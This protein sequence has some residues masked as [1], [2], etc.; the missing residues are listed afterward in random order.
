MKRL[1]SPLLSAEE[2]KNKSITVQELH[3][4]TEPKSMRF[5]EL[6]GSSSSD[7]SRFA[8]RHLRARTKGQNLDE[9]GTD[10]EEQRG[11]PRSKS[12]KHIRRRKTKSG[13]RP[14]ESIC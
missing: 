10:I 9:G 4:A 5:Q 7:V 1:K 3:K 6:T 11:D 8:D 14:S 2:E 13:N 12:D